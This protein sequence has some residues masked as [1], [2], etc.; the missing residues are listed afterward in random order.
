MRRARGGHDFQHL[1]L[2]IARIYGAV[3]HSEPCAHRAGRIDF[4]LP[5][6]IYARWTRWEHSKV[7]PQMWR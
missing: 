2:D 7:W 4:T 6:H 1:K 3:S 5:S